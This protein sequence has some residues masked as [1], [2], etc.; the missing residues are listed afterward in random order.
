MKKCIICGRQ[1]AGYGNNPEPVKRWFDGSCC[2][3]CNR[4][5]SD[6][7]DWCRYNR[8][9]PNARNLKQFRW[10]TYKTLP[11]RQRVWIA[12]KDAIKSYLGPEMWGYDEKEL[13]R[14]NTI[15]ELEEYLQTRHPEDN[16]PNPY[17]LYNE[18]VTP[19]YESIDEFPDDFDY[20]WRY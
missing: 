1:I 18:E 2:D 13:D 17:P 15:D 9:E 14:I 7:L 6:F 5:Q 12:Y 16:W 19:V 20:M 4:E 8:V 3:K 11:E 10:E